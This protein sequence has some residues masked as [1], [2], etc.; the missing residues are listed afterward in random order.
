MSA[1]GH[2]KQALETLFVVDV[3][4]MQKIGSTQ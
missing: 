4:V 2:K 3:N 1:C